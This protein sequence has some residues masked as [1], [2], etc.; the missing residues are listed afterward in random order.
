MP[1]K[2]ADALK[3]APQKPLRLLVALAT[4]TDGLKHIGG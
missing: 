1:N 3:L 2:F 4:D